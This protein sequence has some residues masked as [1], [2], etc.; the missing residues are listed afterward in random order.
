[1]LS[2]AC[3]ENTFFCTVVKDMYE[4]LKS[5]TP[6]KPPKSKGDAVMIDQVQVG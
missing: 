4:E 2:L 6:P 3:W 5:K 1:M